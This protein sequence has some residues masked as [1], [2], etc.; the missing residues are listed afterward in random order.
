MMRP[1]RIL[2]GNKLNNNIDYYISKY[3]IYL[4]IKIKSFFFPILSSEIG[5]CINNDSYE[6]K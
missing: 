6:Y 3:K 4:I 1:T 2:G 5:I